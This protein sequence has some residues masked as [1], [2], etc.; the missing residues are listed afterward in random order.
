MPN[1]LKRTDTD[2][3]TMTKTVDVKVLHLTYYRRD[4]LQHTCLPLAESF[5]RLFRVRRSTSR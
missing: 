5:T 1:L 3:R 2:R 4:L